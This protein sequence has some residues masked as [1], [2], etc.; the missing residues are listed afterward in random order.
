VDKDGRI[1]KDRAADTSGGLKPHLAPPDAFR[2]YFDWYPDGSIEDLR[3]RFTS[4]LR[5]AMRTW[6]VLLEDEVRA[7]GQTRAQWETLLVIV[8]S[9][10]KSTQKLLAERLR[11]EGPT[12]VRLL[13]KLEEDGLIQ[14]VQDTTDRRSKIIRPTRKGIALTKKM[15]K[16]TDAKRAEFLEGWTAEE[17]EEGMALLQRLAGAQ[18]ESR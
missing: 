18:T 7:A 1:A 12:L 14:R 11:I 16:R 2:R 15:V 4:R 3:F 6:R 13:D 17:L 8:L 9:G 10:G 5:E